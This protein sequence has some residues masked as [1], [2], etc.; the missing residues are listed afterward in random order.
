[1]V[2]QLSDLWV[3]VLEKHQTNQQTQAVTCVYCGTKYTAA[4]ASTIARHLKGCKRLPDDV[5]DEIGLP[6]PESSRSSRPSKRQRLSTEEPPESLA[7]SASAMSQRSSVRAT[8]SVSRVSATSETASTSS[9]NSKGK[10][11]K[12]ET[13]FDTI[14]RE[15]EKDLDEA[16]ARAWY[17]AGLPFSAIDNTFVRAVFKKLRPAYEPPT[18]KRLAGSLLEEIDRIVTL[19]VNRALRKADN[20]TIATDGMTNIIKESCQNY[21]AM[22]PTPYFLECKAT[23]EDRHTAEYIAQE[24]TGIIERLGPTKGNL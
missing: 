1:M 12:I 7:E 16:V 23:G 21:M 19:E 11:R 6:T 14:N 2:R 13:W 17:V 10:S 5:R 20:I 3:H 8:T 18:R 24:V 15:E 4:G 22:T 9:S